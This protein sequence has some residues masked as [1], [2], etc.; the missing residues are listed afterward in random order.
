M[1][2]HSK[3]QLPDAT[4][5]TAAL[6]RDRDAEGTAAVNVL[7]GTTVPDTVREVPTPFVGRACTAPIA[8][9]PIRPRHELDFIKAEVWETSLQAGCVLH[10]SLYPYNVIM[11]L[12][13]TEPTELTNRFKVSVGAT[14]KSEVVS[15]FEFVP[16]ADT[17]TLSMSTGE[18]PENA[19]GATG[20]RK[21]DLVQRHGLRP[22]CG[23][24]E[25]TLEA[26][27]VEA[28][29]GKIRADVSVREFGNN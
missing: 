20:F 4:L 17:E 7:T 26:K 2:I 19:D 13:A 11:D 18:N 25:Y 10:K 1:A 15:P 12:H 16:A 23:K 22:C 27:V 24:P 14:S 21:V 3:F 28:V 8:A 9:K 29:W 5:C 6:S